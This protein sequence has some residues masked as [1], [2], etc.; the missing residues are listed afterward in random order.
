MDNRMKIILA[1]VIVV[2]LILL[3]LT[4]VKLHQQK[5]MITFLTTQEKRKKT[6]DRIQWESG[7]AEELRLLRKRMELSTLQEQINPH[8]L[9]NT[10]DSI[11]SRALMDGQ[12]EI[13]QMTEILSRFFRYCISNSDRLVRVREE[14]NHIQDYY[15]IQKY[16][17]E[18]KLDMRIEVETDEIYDY[19]L[20]KMTLQPLVENAMIHGLEKS[21]KKGRI[22]LH[23]FLAN[24]RLV[25]LVADNGVGMNP[26]QL[27][28]LNER[29]SGQMYEAGR[30]G[31]RHSG[32]ALNNVNARLKLTF[33][34]GSGIHYRSME[35]EGTDAVV[36]MPVVDVFAR[37]RYEEKSQI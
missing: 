26:E 37:V 33:G 15:Y 25:I 9:Y 28:S 13:A 4:C 29:M 31:S 34:E 5:K 14:L 11:R 20:P 30:K 1:A 6:Q 10:L 8:F 19:Y 21:A 18:D 3:I 24:E 22:D 2:L 17:F 32:I 12:T 27:A 36:T 7:E 23:I 35:G 16:R